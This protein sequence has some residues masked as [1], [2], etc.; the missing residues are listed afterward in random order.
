M[1]THAVVVLL[2]LVTPAGLLAA[3]EPNDRLVRLKSLHQ[4]RKWQE[5]ISE[6]SSEDFAAWPSVSAQQASEALHLRGQAYA[7]LKSG[8]QAEADLQAALKLSPK[9]VLILHALAE[10]YVN[11]LRDERQAL[12][13]YRQVFKLTGK[14]NGWLPIST[15]LAIARILTDQVKTSEALEVL[16]QYGDLEGMAPVWRIKVLRAYGHAYAAQGQETESLAKFREA[17]ELESRQ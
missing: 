5:L 17:L 1:K 15:T 14:S 12:E 10:N 7:F 2:L 13:S 9:N 6:F 3:N 4:E 8:A 11:N 16:Q